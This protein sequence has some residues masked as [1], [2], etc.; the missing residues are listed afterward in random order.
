MKKVSERFQRC[1][2]SGGGGC[3]RTCVCGRTFFNGQQQGG[4][5]AGELEEL[6]SKNA[7]YPDTC[8]ETDFTISTHIV[9]G[10]EYV[11]DCPCGGPIVFEQ[12]L[13]DQAR[14]IAHY[15]NATATAHRMVADDMSV[16][17]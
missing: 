8:V 2:A 3:R 9:M 17:R 14:Q 16:R 13:L 15:L 12:G 4:W 11:M 6:K 1:F 10:Q 5:E 7:T